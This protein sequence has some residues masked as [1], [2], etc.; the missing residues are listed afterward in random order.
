MSTMADQIQELEDIQ[1][2]AELSGW[3]PAGSKVK[4]MIEACNNKFSA[5]AREI[6]DVRVRDEIRPAL[7][8]HR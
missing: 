8:R 4:K 7:E 5:G 2:I 3:D 1:K 6:S